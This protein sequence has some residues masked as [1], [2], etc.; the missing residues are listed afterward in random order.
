MPVQI[1]FAINRMTAPRLNL[2]DF[3]TFARSAGAQGG[4]VRKDLEE[5][6]F[7]DGMQP[8]ADSAN[9]IDA[10]WHRKE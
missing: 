1:K 5:Q 2:D 8:A 10:K 4:E 6:E 3:L 7:A 9:W